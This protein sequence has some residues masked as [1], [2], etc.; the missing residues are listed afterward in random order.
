MLP[1][2]TAP[3]R[4]TVLLV[5]GPYAGQTINVDARLRSWASGDYAPVEAHPSGQLPQYRYVNT[6]YHFHECVCLGLSVLLGWCGTPPD[7]Q[8]L[9]KHLLSREALQA[10]SPLHSAKR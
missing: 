3:G 8:Q 5:D 1:P 4:R 6:V 7:Q 2:F 9:A 10:S